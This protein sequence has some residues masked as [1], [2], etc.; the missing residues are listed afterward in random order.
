[1][2]SRTAEATQ[3]KETLSGKTKKKTTKNKK[4]NQPKMNPSSLKR[5]QTILNVTA[6]NLIEKL[7]VQVS[8][9]L[10][11]LFVCFGVLFCFSR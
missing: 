5:I 9:G 11:F 6:Y 8:G 4:T 10:T 2:S 7:K 1:V 3:G